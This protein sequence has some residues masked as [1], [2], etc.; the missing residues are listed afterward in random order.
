MIAKTGPI[1]Y[2]SSINTN[3]ITL[4]DSH[5]PTNKGAFNV[6]IFLMMRHGAPQY[7]MGEERRLPNYTTFSLP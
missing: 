3:P 4:I 1:C 2:S 5:Y 7:D 6:T